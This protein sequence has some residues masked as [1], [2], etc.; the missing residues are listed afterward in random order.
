MVR[1][2][3]YVARGNIP[4]A[5]NDVVIKPVALVRS[6]TRMCNWRRKINIAATKVF[7]TV[8]TLTAVD[9]DEI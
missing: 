3:P 8:K 4:K 6:E 2:F 7:L 9:Y 1:Q 5:K